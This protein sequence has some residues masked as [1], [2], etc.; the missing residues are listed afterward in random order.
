MQQIESPNNSRVKMA[1]RLRSPRGRVQQNRIVIDGIR[2]SIRA[3]QAQLEVTELFVCPDLVNDELLTTILQTASHVS[4]KNII[5]LPKIVFK[6]IAFGDRADGVVVVA[7]RPDTSPDRLDVPQEPLVAVLESFEKPGNLG[8]VLRSAD[9][10]G[11]D[12]VLIASPLTDLFH[13]NAIR[14]SVG[15]VFHL[16]IAVAST[17]ICIKWLASKNLKCFA[18]KPESEQL[19]FDAQFVNGSAIVLGNEAKGLSDAWSIPSVSGIKL[20]MCGIAD[21]LNVASAATAVF[22]E[23]FRQRQT[24]SKAS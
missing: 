15:C 16:P 9:G 1:A 20:P 17:D 23:A 13:P 11:I 21:S 2:E 4:P 6:K 7:N 22:Y 10:A 8:A 3:L 12:A 24:A 18:A 14:N 19:Y 5:S